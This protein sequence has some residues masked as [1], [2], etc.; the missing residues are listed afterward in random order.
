MK[1]HHNYHH[2][3]PSFFVFPGVGIATMVIVFFLDIYYCTIIAWTL[4]Y[5]IGSFSA[6]PDLPWDTCGGINIIFLARNDHLKVYV[7]FH[8]FPEGWWNTDFCYR[9]DSTNQTVNEMNLANHT[10]IHNKTTTPV[11]EFWE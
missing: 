11:E 10:K 3:F 4:F 1:L 9:A 6:I 7:S 5:L 2:I 8:F